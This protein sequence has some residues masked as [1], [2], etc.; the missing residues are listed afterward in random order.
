[1]IGLM[2]FSAAIYLLGAAGLLIIRIMPYFK[3]GSSAPQSKSV[4]IILILMG[5]S[6]LILA[7]GTG[8]CSIM[9]LGM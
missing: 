8:L 2:V 9:F 5:V 1:M 4:K 6:G 3:S 7:V